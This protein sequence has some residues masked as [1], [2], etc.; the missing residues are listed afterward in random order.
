M[1]KKNTRVVVRRVSFVGVARTI[2]SDR[3]RR[4][5]NPAARNH[6]FARVFI[7]FSRPRIQRKEKK[8]AEQYPARAE[9]TPP[10]DR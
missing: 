1:N 2:L 3:T 4:E 9:K 7:F 6:E 10:P 5:R 8:S